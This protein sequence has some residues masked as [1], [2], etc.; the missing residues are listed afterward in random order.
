MLVLSLYVLLLTCYYVNL[1]TYFFRFRILPTPALL[2]HFRLASLSMLVPLI[3]CPSHS[4][5]KQYRLSQDILP[6]PE[7]LEKKDFGQCA[8][9]SDGVV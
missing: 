9:R 4:I 8:I 1:D 6:K 3:S 2:S 7:G 5:Y